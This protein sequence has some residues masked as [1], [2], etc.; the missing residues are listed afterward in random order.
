MHATLAVRTASDKSRNS[1][2]GP[3]QKQYIW[4][5]YQ[6]NTTTGRGAREGDKMQPRGLD[7]PPLEQEALEGPRHELG[8]TNHV[9]INAKEFNAES[10]AAWMPKKSVRRS[11]RHVSGPSLDR[12]PPW[13]RT[14]WMTSIDRPILVQHRAAVARKES[15]AV[16]AAALPSGPG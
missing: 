2:A 15:A 11:G 13:T 1:K 8:R 4:T 14:S 5:S 7:R 9:A 12:Q 3:P 10:T 16:R 6:E